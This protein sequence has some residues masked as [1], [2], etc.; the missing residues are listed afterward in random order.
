M[1]AL[2]V[3]ICVVS[4]AVIAGVIY[5]VV[6]SSRQQASTDKDYANAVQTAATRQD[7]LSTVLSDAKEP[8][9]TLTE[10]LPN[11]SEVE[12]FSQTW[13]S[14]ESLLDKPPHYFSVTPTNETQTHTALSQLTEYNTSLANVTKRLRTQTETAGLSD[15]KS[16]FTSSKTSLTT[17]TEQARLVMKNYTSQKSKYKFS[18]SNT[19]DSDDSGSS[20][21]SESATDADAD[22]DGALVSAVTTSLDDGTKLLDAKES[23]TPAEIASAALQMEKSATSVKNAYDALQKGVNE[24]VTKSQEK[25]T[26]N[27]DLESANGAL[28]KALQGTWK[29]SKGATMTFTSTTLQSHHAKA[30]RISTDD[31]TSVPAPA[32]T[33]IVAGWT[34]T[35]GGVSGGV[36]DTTVVLYQKTTDASAQSLVV[37][38]AGSRWE[39]TR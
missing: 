33:K 3:I 36:E 10:A 13:S 15:A 20:D 7:A 32:G 5:F 16:L 14:A 9:K 4:C 12:S 34:L 35:A 1:I 24:A 17:A 39:L 28:P 29:T 23:G 25:K 38:T 2:T 31:L 22:L 21:D 27:S 30:T 8:L 18:V 6:A 26:Q 37:S 11:S 19:S